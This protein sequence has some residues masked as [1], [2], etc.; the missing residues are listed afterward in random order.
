MR[1]WNVTCACHAPADTA[2]GETSWISHGFPQSK[3]SE[4]R[5]AGSSGRC[6]Q[7]LTSQV[8]WSL[9]YIVLPHFPLYCNKPLTLS[10]GLLNKSSH[11]L[12]CRWFGVENLKSFG[13]HWLIGDRTSR[14]AQAAFIRC[15]GDMF[16]HTNLGQ[17]LPECTWNSPLSPKVPHAAQCPFGS[18][19]HEAQITALG[20][21]SLILV[22]NSGLRR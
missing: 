22:A 10:T 19:P 2:A 8:H 15:C 5:S 12:S 9:S 14:T 21:A 16:F 4:L 18:I 1:G 20:C 7:R 11:Q 3:S 6:L 13:Q 17:K